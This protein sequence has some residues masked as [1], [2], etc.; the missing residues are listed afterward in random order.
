MPTLCISAVLPDILSAVPDAASTYGSPVVINVLAN[1]FVPPATV[2][3]VTVRLVTAPV[4]GTA[5]I[6]ADKAAVIYTPPAAVASTLMDMFE[7]VIQDGVL[8]TSVASKTTVTVTV[9]PTAND[10]YTWVTIGNHCP[11]GEYDICIDDACAKLGTAWH[12]VMVSADAPRQYV[13]AMRVGNTWVSGKSDTHSLRWPYPTCW[14]WVGAEQY[15][16][17]RANISWFACSNCAAANCHLAWVEPATACGIPVPI[18]GSG[19][20]WLGGV[21]KATYPTAL[22]AGGTQEWPGSWNSTTCISGISEEYGGEGFATA[23]A[24]ATKLC[25]VHWL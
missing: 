1:D 17:Y 19:L 9:F 14:V 11:S 4:L 13:C 24:G 7:Y 23:K 20:P 2:L 12:A 6:T 22:V 5:A 21:C 18:L 16:S 10:S 15:Y 25:P 8:A 3:P